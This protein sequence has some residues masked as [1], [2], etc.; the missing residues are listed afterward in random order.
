MLGMARSHDERGE[1]LSA[2]HLL[3]NS[4]PTS[5]KLQLAY[6]KP[7]RSASRQDHLLHLEHCIYSFNFAPKA[8]NSSLVLGFSNWFTTSGEGI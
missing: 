5:L 6:I 3:Y 1:R 4:S 2:Q 8:C 7:S